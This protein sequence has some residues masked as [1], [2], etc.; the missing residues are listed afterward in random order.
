[1]KALRW[2]KPKEKFKLS[3]MK[4]KNKY[5]KKELV[6]FEKIIL[7]KIDVASGELNYIKE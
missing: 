3:I 6:E 5:S 4:K 1:M 2:K 7:K